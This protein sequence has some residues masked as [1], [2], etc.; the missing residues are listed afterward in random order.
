MET[1]ISLLRLAHPRRFG[2]IGRGAVIPGSGVGGFERARLRDIGAKKP[3]DFCQMRAVL[4]VPQ[5]VLSV[6]GSCDKLLKTPEADSC[7]MRIFRATLYCRG[8]TREI[9]RIWRGVYRDFAS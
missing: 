7:S 8:K 2:G 5:P 6:A 9:T 4:S 3:G 1:G